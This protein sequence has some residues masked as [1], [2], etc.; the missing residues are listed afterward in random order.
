M[1]DGEKRGADDCGR[2]KAV[3]FMIDKS[4]ILLL[5]WQGT[6]RLM[7]ARQSLL[8]SAFTSSSSSN[9]GSSSS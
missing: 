7:T 6:R 3:H 9:P 2:R 5:K 8:P 4:L 1:E